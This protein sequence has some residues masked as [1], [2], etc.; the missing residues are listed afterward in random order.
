MDEDA[1]RYKRNSGQKRIKNIIYAVLTAALVLMVALAWNKTIE[2]IID[3]TVGGFDRVWGYLIYSILI[4]GIALLIV[5]LL[6][7]FLGIK[8]DSLTRFNY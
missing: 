7:R 6:A 2:F 3:E 4:T 5:Y 8:D 1:V